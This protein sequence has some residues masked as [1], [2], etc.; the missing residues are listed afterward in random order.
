VRIVNGRGEVL[1]FGGQVMK[2]VAGYDLSRLTA[3]ALGTLGVLLEAS[4]KVLPAPAAELTLAQEIDAADAIAAMNR[5]AG[6]PLPLSA[7]AHWEGRLYL[8]LSGSASGVES[9]RRVIGGER[10]GAGPWADLREHRLPFF[11]GDAPLWRLSVPPTSPPLALPGSWVVDWG[12][13]QR[14]LRTDA[15]PERVRAVAGAAGGHATLFRGGD[16]SGEV[17]HPLATG[18]ATL[19]RRLK[20]AFDPRGILNPSRLYRDL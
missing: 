4:L 12:G 3:G 18:V 8:R 5:Y 19:H 17:F 11:R 6:R 14:W 20:Q 13:A 16:R 9:A 1:R 10:L 15:D 2:N 7:A